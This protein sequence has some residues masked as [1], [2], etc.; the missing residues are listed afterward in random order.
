MT[1]R[2]LDLS[3]RAVRLRVDTGR[4]VIHREQGADAAIPLADVAVVVASHPQVTYT[5]AVLAGLVENGAAFV[6]CDR[7]RLPVGMLLPLDAHYVQTERFAL[8]ASASRPTRK[9]L[10]QQL[11][12]A[13]VKAQGRLLECLHGDDAGLKALARDV[14][15][16]D[17]SNVE[18]QASRRYWPALFADTSFR[19]DPNRDDQ[20][21]LLN[22]G[23]AVLR[24][25][26]ARALC[27]AGLHPSLGIHH[28]NR[29][30]SFCLADDVMEPFRPRVDEAVWK[31][32]QQHGPQAPLG[33]E[34]KAG[35]VET[36]SRRVALGG[37]NL[38]LFQALARTA[39]SLVAVL[40]RRGKKLLL[41][42]L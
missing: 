29:Y 16:G 30:N 14:R 1:D 37:Q 34:V 23:Y 20:N 25:A 35:L 17:P 21:R 8:Q 27:A 4:L 18:A 13:K 41:P 11:V 42:E 19:R 24:A 9:R 32:V 15:S 5:Q 3:E 22:Y 38:S 26:V 6:V 10:W 28:H 12:R 39:S 7:R 33:G 2:I 31:L 36:I 40:A